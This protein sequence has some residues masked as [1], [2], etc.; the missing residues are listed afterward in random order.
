MGWKFHKYFERKGYNI[1]WNAGEF[2]LEEVSELD[3][4]VEFRP[5]DTKGKKHLRTFL[6]EEVDES[7]HEFIQT[8]VFIETRNFMNRVKNF[9]K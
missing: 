4:E 5:E 9:R 8:N 2:N 3:I 6:E 1:I 7:L